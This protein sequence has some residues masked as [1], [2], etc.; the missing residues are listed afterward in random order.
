MLLVAMLGFQSCGVG[1]VV[2]GDED[3][4]IVGAGLQ[5]ELLAVVFR[6]P[7]HDLA[8]EGL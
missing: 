3:P 4:V 2:V 1:G 5:V 8:A 7:L 6:D